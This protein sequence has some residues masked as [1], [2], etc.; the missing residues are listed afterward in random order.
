M[1]EQLQSPPAIMVQRFCSIPAETFS[2][3]EQVT[4]MP[5][6]HFSKVNVHRGTIIMFVPDGFT[7]AEGVHEGTQ[8]RVGQALMRMPEKPLEAM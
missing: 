1:N 6:L 7:L 2:A 8:I 5:P 3:Q 4:F